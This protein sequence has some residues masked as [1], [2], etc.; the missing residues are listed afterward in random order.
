LRFQGSNF[1][2]PEGVAGLL[3]VAGTF[4]TLRRLGIAEGEGTVKVH[5]KHAEKLNLRSRG[6]CSV[7]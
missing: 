7:D 3:G 6:V 1:A 2:L 4:E 5:L